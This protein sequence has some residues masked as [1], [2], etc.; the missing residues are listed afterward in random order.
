M[1]E[2]IVAKLQIT[3]SLLA[4]LAA[5]ALAACNRA[6]PTP[7]TDNTPIQTAVVAAYPYQAA[8]SAPQKATAYPEPDAIAQPT[9]TASSPSPTPYL[10]PTLIPPIIISQTVLN[11]AAQNGLVKCYDETLQIEFERPAVWGEIG[12]VLRE[13]GDAGYAYDYSFTGQAFAGGFPLMAG[14]RSKDFGEGR[15][16]MYTDFLGYGDNYSAQNRCSDMRAYTPICEEI[17]TDVALL[18]KFPDARSICESVPGVLFTPI[19]LLEIN[20]PADATISGFVFVTPFLSE[21]ETD[22]LVA[23]MRD[24]LGYDPETGGAAM[25]GDADQETFDRRMAELTQ[26]VRIDQI[27]DQTKESITQIRKLGASVIFP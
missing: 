16:G 4:L 22:D 21:A 23:D 15:G 25:C 7:S 18:M 2:Y 6:A 14:G 20:L 3:F 10:P 9:Q 5:I 24:I 8:T 1:Y 17:Q 13:G 12:A 19:I 26:R 11:C 27:D